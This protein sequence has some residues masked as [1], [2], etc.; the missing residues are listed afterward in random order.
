MTWRKID[1]HID[2][3]AS[4]FCFRHQNHNHTSS[5]TA[6]QGNSSRKLISTNLITFIS[7]TEHDHYG[8][9]CADL[10][11]YFSVNGA[12]RGANAAEEE[13]N[14]WINWWMKNFKSSTLDSAQNDE[15]IQENK[16][17]L[18][19]LKTQTLQTLNTNSG[20][21]FKFDATK[22]FSYKLLIFF[23][24]VEKERDESG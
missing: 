18:R 17:T 5:N 19:F 14:R 11:F 1:T 10:L 24:D 20:L 7:Q 22:F 13:T 3:S 12:M 15:T 16:T 2:F 6:L 4:A 9:V 23:T 8:R 21:R